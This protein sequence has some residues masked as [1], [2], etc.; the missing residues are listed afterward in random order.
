[1]E[2]RA[3]EPPYLHTLPLVHTRLF[4]AWLP[5]EEPVTRLVASEVSDVEFSEVWT[6]RAEVRF[7]DVPDADL[8]GLAPVEVGRGYVFSYAETLHHG[9]ALE[10]A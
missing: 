2:G 8:A 9:Q 1:I 4:P 7:P 3:A 6:G 5:S 10:P